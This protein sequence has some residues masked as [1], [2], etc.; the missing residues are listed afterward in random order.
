MIMTCGSLAPRIDQTLFDKVGHDVQFHLG[1]DS[2]LDL[3]KAVFIFRSH[4]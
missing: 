2:I 4:V 1:I 3:D